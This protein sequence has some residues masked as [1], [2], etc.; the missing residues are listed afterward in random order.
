MTKKQLFFSI[1][2]PVKSYVKKF[3]EIN[4]GNP[5]DFSHHTEENAFLQNLLK[6]PSRR[7]DYSIK[8]NGVRYQDVIEINISEDMFY[9]YGWELTKTNA[10]K[11]GKFFESRIKLFMR[12]W[13]GV[14][15]SIGIP[16]FRSIHNFQDKY[17]FDEDDWKFEAIKKDFYRNAPK[18]S[19]DFYHE[20]HYKIHKII[21]DNLYDSGTISHNI[22]KEH[23][24]NSKAIR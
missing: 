19:I 13:I 14:E 15:T 2:V 23:E 18:Q 17:N 24:R 1:Q 9:R 3:L 10:L 5:V 20:I 12:T 22:I 4:F 16:L 8:D 6:K 11:F 21:L 7:R